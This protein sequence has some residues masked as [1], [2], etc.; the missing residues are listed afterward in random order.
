MCGGSGGGGCVC[1]HLCSDSWTS[2]DALVKH[3]IT[4][5]PLSWESRRVLVHAGNLAGQG[6]ILSQKYSE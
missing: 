4:G 2:R 6:S 3:P 1:V 5:K